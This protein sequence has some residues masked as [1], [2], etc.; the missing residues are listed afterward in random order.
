M[1]PGGLCMAGNSFGA[2][3]IQKAF[4]SDPHGWRFR[5]LRPKRDGGI[6]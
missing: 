4:S 1:R 6:L 2:G 5:I 3:G